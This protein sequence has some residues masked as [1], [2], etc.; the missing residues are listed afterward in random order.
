ME[1]KILWA[2]WRGEYVS[3]KK[4][5]GC[6]F[7]PPEGNLPDEERLIL[8]R[9]PFVLVIMNKF[10]YNA[11]HLLIAPKRH[12][13]ELEQLT[14]EEVTALMKMAQEA[15]KILKEVFK[16]HG[17]NVGFNLGKVAGA[18]YPDHLH[19]QIV[20]RWEGDVNFLAVLDEVR[21]ISQHLLTQYRIL[22]PYFQ[23]IKL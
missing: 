1:R 9:D 13:A 4:D 11:G 12:V 8:Y 20:P 3:G 15:I 19:L 18:G 14:P 7:C 17:F 10:P 16:P 23:K 21:V 5:L 22:F 6:I 2:P